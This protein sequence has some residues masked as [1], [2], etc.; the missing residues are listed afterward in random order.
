[1]QFSYTQSE[2]TNKYGVLKFQIFFFWNTRNFEIWGNGNCLIS[3]INKHLCYNLVNFVSLIVFEKPIVRDQIGNTRYN[4]HLYGKVTYVK[5]E[6]YYLILRIKKT[7]CYSIILQ[8]I[9]QI[10][11]KTKINI[12]Y[13]LNLDLLICKTA[14]ILSD[15]QIWAIN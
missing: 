11:L 5:I 8:N 9:L 1:M 14:T 4:S 2:T 13:T 7:D 10:K 12:L 3:Y 6:N 15:A